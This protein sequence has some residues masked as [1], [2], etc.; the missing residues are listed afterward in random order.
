MITCKIQVCRGL[1]ARTREVCQAKV[2]P[3][4]TAR[5]PQQRGDSFPEFVPR[6][7]IRHAAV[8]VESGIA[9]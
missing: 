5:R 7:A 8:Y 6:T 4:V 9:S 1:S 2:D 3:F